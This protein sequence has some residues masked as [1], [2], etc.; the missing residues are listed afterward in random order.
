MNAVINDNI[1]YITFHGDMT[2][3]HMD[4]FRTVFTAALA[5]VDM[6]YFDVREMILPSVSLMWQFGR[7]M[8]SKRPILKG[9]KTFIKA[10]K[11]V[12]TFLN[13]FFLVFKPSTEIIWVTE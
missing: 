1:F 8:L 6:F 9:K 13:S 12:R 2:Q 5:K 3:D 7:F 4:Q 10:N 11:K